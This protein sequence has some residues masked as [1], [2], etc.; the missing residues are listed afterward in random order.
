[1]HT[2]DY[3]EQQ[4]LTLLLCAHAQGECLR[5]RCPYCEYERQFGSLAERLRFEE[6]QRARLLA[7][8]LPASRD[9]QYT[10]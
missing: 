1:M 2:K 6:A 8:W 10:P 4:S 9:E 3:F 5:D 7:L